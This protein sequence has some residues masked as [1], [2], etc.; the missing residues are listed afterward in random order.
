MNNSVKSKPILEKREDGLVLTDGNLTMM[1]DFTDMI[2]RLRP[3]NLNGEILVRAAKGKAASGD[4]LFAIDATAGMGED[5]LLLAAAGFTVRLYEKDPV[6]AALLS[7]SVERAKSV[8]ELLDAV[9]RMTVLNGDSIEAMKNPDV[10]P[11]VILLDPMFPKREKSGLIKKKFQL[12]QQLEKPCDDEAALLE[13]ALMAGPS[14]IVIKRPAKGPYLAG[15]KPSYSI[16]GKS[17][18]YDVIVP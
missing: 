1:G 12:I 14:K 5:A 18:R 15:R 11:D 9:S 3:N 13:A 7:D 4:G 6:I 2:P 8:P 10:K 16:N 17:I